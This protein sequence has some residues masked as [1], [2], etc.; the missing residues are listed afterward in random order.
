[1]QSADFAIRVIQI[2]ESQRSSL[3]GV[4]AGWGGFTV[5]PRC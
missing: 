1:Y 3:A 2:P 4:N 5:Y